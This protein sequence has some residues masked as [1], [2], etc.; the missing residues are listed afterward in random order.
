MGRVVGGWEF[1][2]CCRWSGW[3]VEVL[4]R[5][6]VEW[7]EGGGLESLVQDGEKIREWRVEEKWK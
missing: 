3:R 4:E 5:L 1:E 2:G 7:L 6:W